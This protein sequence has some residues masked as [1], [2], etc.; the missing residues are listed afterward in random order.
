MGRRERRKE[1]VR[2]AL[3][4]A[5]ITLF[6]ERGIHAAR[7]EDITEHADLG[8]GAF[9]NYFPSK[10]ALV[11][12]LLHEGVDLLEREYLVGAATASTQS[13]R[14]AN[15]VGSHN[16]FFDEHPQYVLLF[17]QAR[18]LL[19][20]GR[21]GSDRMRE[22]FGDYLRRIGALLEHPDPARPW[23][24]DDRADFAAAVVGAIAGYRSY[25]LAAGHPPHAATIASVMT[26]G[27]PQLIRDRA[28]SPRGSEDT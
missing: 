21:G 12:E 25:R 26:S 3:L 22:V 18:G 27:L 2:R 24:E 19:T 15:V 7:V 14:I 9:Y 10:D 11:A 13:E 4:D 1:A 5:A 23:S 17:H 28:G 16:A 6:T 20:L 8:K